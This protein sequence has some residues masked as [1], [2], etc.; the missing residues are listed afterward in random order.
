MGIPKAVQNHGDVSIV[1][2][3]D[4][5][6]LYNKKRNTILELDFRLFQTRGTAISTPKGEQPLY[7]EHVK[8][9]QYTWRKDKKSDKRGLI[10]Y[11]NANQVVAQLQFRGNDKLIS[12]GKLF[13]VVQF[14]KKSNSARL[15]ELA[16]WSGEKQNRDYVITLPA[17]QSVVD[18]EMKP[19]FEKNKVFVLGMS[20]ASKK[21]WRKG[22]IFDYEKGWE[23]GKYK[24][25][26]GSYVSYGGISPDGSKAM[27]IVSNVKTGYV[28]RILM[29]SFSSRKW[30]LVKKPSLR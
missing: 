28:E 27:M 5:S 15:K 16:R 18:A 17:N 14:D 22:F 4:S 24:P 29:L 9:M 13:G 10:A 21:R 7:V 19:N 20:E 3:K 23:V 6:Y 12:N 11:R 26:M 1:R 30:T 25:K 8:R 2:S